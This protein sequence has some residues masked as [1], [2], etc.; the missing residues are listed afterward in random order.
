LT[1]EEY[2]ALWAAYSSSVKPTASILPDE[3]TAMDSPWTPS[4]SPN[5]TF[6]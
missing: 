1:I 2:L 4:P 3:K 6:L 5:H